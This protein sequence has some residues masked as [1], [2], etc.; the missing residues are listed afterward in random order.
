MEGGNLTG[1]GTIFYAAL[2]AIRW[3]ARFPSFCNAAYLASVL[4][5]GVAKRITNGPWSP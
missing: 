4:V 1:Y 3:C 2:N 5:L